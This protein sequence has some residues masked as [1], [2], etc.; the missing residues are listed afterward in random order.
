MGTLKI[1]IVLIQHKKR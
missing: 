1:Y